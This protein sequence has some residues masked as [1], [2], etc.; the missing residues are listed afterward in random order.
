V[1][2]RRPYD[3][4]TP[5][6]TALGLLVTFATPEEVGQCERAL[7]QLLW[8]SDRERSCVFAHA[9]EELH[10]SAQAWAEVPRRPSAS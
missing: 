2:F 7:E 10:L 1:K 8:E 5:A 9:L 3:S 6:R 4:P